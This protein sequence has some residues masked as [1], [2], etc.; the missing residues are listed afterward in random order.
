MMMT[1]GMRH[2]QTQG[3]ARWTT[4]RDPGAYRQVPR[5]C[6][7]PRKGIRA[8]DDSE[9]SEH[10]CGSPETQSSPETGLGG[11]VAAGRRRSISYRS[12]AVVHPTLIEL[13]I[14]WI[15]RCT[16]ASA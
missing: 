11:H 12:T 8:Q 5:L 2:G 1:V 4:R 10:Y 14:P 7:P 16:R 13:A 15:G 6:R 3:Q 9:L